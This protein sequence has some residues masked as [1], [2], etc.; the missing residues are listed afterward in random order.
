MGSPT[1]APTLTQLI[2]RSIERG[3]VPKHWKI[4]TV[5]PVLKKG[6]PKLVENYRPV[7]CLPAASKLLESV[8]CKQVTNFME[9][10]GILPKNQHGFREHR[11]TMT[12]WSDIQQD[13]AM[14][15]ENKEITGVLLWDLSAAF[16][17]LEH[18]I[19]CSKLEIYGFDSCSVSWM[20]SFLM[21]RQ[22]MVKIGDANSS[23]VPLKSGVPQGGIIS[24]L[25]YI[26]YVAD[27]EEWLQV[28]KAITYADD[29]S[30]SA[31]S[32]CLTS[33]INR[34]EKDA[35]NV[36]KFMASNGL[37]ANPKKTVFML[38]NHKNQTNT[39]VEIKIG[40]V[41]IQQEHQ[42]KLLGM[43][44]NDKQKW[45]EQIRDPGGLIPTLNKRLF[46]IRRLKNQLG[47][48]ELKKVAESLYI[49]KLRYGAQL[50]G[51]I[52]WSEEDPKTADLRSIQV[53][54]NKM[55]RLISNSTIRDRQDM[56]LLFQELGWLSFNQMNAQVKI[57][58]AWKMVTIPNYPNKFELKTV[59]PNGRTTRSISNEVVIEPGG[60]NLGTATFISD[61]A[62]AWNKY[63]LTLKDI[64][65]VYAAKKEI[66]EIV[67]TL[68]F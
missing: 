61:A 57:L 1:L 23:L 62:R 21:D 18:G 13:W 58:E 47:K 16:D 34:L 26:V 29:T 19:L 20:K 28:A 3:E 46:L 5:T 65:S 67:K 14:N 45:S 22:Q 53:T 68:P 49:S 35:I 4:G 32:K 60:S 44:I 42:A 37:V 66:K 41:T 11:S 52:R 33:V 56:K 50:L 24:P 17:T 31:S 64:S 63:S 12:A 40:N 25:L 10:N 36:L 39:P 15:T 6:D 48:R 7:T 9:S 2:N 51:K 59:E 30:T 27:L 38:L 54:F 43:S 55:A 8:V